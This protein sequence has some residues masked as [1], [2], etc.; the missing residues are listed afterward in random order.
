MTGAL[1]R[2]ELVALCVGDLVTDRAE[3]LEVMLRKSKTDQ[4]RLGRVVAIPDTAT[5]SAMSPRAEVLGWLDWLGRCPHQDPSDPE[6]LPL[7]ATAPVFRPVSRR[8]GADARARIGIKGLS[9]R[10]ISEIV[11]YSSRR[12]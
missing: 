1:R 10:A 6:R 9:D 2:S 11:K 4:H 7:P 12:S 3:G 5:G 8:Q